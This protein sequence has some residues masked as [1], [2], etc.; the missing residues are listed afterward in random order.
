MVRHPQGIHNGAVVL[1]AAGAD[2]ATA[3]DALH[4]R[5]AMNLASGS[6]DA[7]PTTEALSKL[8]A[9]SQN[10]PRDDAITA[11]AMAY[12]GGNWDDD[13]DEINAGQYTRDAATGAFRRLFESRKGLRR[14]SSMAG[15]HLSRQGSMSHLHANVQQRGRPLP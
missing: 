11:E 8:G 4:A 10:S 14:H 9:S 3:T 6:G 1:T 12:G 15:N 13:D 7:L 2:T 5:A